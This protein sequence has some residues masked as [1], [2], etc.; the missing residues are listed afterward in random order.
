MSQIIQCMVVSWNGLREIVK[1]KV[2]PSEKMVYYWKY[3]YW[4]QFIT[5]IFE[6]MVYYWKYIYLKQFITFIFEKMVYYWKYIYLKQFITFTFEKMV[7]YWKY[8]YLKQFITFIFEVAVM[9]L[10]IQIIKCKN[11]CFFY[12]KFEVPIITNATK[13][14]PFRALLTSLKRSAY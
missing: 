13:Y 6:K 7:Y 11:C 4:K 8:I 3:I 10:P 9:Q 5:F 1:R 14:M 2:F 12:I